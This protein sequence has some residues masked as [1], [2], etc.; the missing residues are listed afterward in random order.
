MPS[1]FPG[2]DPYLECSG[3]WLD[4]QASLLTCIRDDLNRSLGPQYVARLGERVIAAASERERQKR[5]PGI[6]VSKAKGSSR[7]TGAAEHDV[8]VRIR[9]ELHQHVERYITIMDPKGA[10][11]VAVIE[12][13]SPT[14]KTPGAGARQHAEKQGEVLESDTHLVE[15]DLLRGGDWTVA[16]PEALARRSTEFDCL[17]SVS[18]AQDRGEFEVYPIL[19]E[20]RLPRIGIP[21]LRRDADV[22]ADLQSVHDRCYDRGRYRESLDYA[23]DPEPP[24]QKKR[25]PW[26]RS[27]LRKAGLRRRR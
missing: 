4:V 1:P 23:R 24:L 18:R 9:M 27:V 13:L 17:V 22:V 6:S 19:L 26:V 10:K 3:T 25:L 15:I 5:L 12:L 7:A 2:L 16:V 20:R 14:N 21:L 8:P 11:I